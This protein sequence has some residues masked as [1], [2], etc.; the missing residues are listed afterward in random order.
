ME[1][2]TKALIMTATVLLGIML[3]S[4]M[5]YTFRA[6]ARVD[7]QYESNQS[8]RNIELHNSK[9]EVYNRNDNTI[10]DLID[11]CGLA[12]SNNVDCDYDEALSIE[13][14]INIGSKTY[15]IPSSFP[16]S[17]REPLT[18]YKAE[19]IGMVDRLQDGYA[20]NRIWDGSSIISIYDLVNKSCGDLH[21]SGGGISSED[22]LTKTYTGLATY[23]RH[24]DRTG[25]D[26]T[27]TESITVY[28]YYF[29]CTSVEYNDVTH[30]VSRMT[31][32][33]S[34]NS[35][36]IPFQNND[37]RAWHSSYE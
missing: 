26:E 24:N 12:Y 33:L 25:V 28:K 15:T 35:D 27:V 31:F 29:K 8:E 37:I 5:M 17:A 21:I 36:F 19:Q 10:M 13:I 16:E 3:L 18:A 6:A 23:R 1:N 7:E 20:K 9:F 11:L 2:A 22:R 34:S 4:L 14:V 32:T 30:K